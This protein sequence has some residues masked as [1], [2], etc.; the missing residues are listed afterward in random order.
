MGAGLAEAFKAGVK[1]E[2][3]FVTSKVWCTYVNSPERVVESLEKSL[4]ALGLEYL[5]LLMVHWPV[6][7]NP[8]GNHDRFPTLENGSRDILHGHSHIDTWKNMELVLQTGKVK[9]IGV[10]NVRF[11]F[12]F[13]SP[14]LCP[15]R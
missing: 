1:R 10:S 5:D 12:C 3:I 13:S 9:A 14:V 7:M 11:L 2:D 4:K 8:K 15:Y 6:A